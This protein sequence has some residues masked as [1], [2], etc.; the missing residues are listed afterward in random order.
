MTGPHV[1]L[2]I[3]ASPTSLAALS[4]AARLARHHHC[5]L[6]ALFVEDQDLLASAGHPFTREISALSGE[7]RPFD[8]EI[9]L[10]RLTQQRRQIEAV[11]TELNRDAPLRWH[12]EVVA[13][14][15]F[16]SIH[17]AAQAADWVV[18]GKA[19][20]SADHGAQLGSVARRLLETGGNRLLLWQSETGGNARPEPPHHPA[21]TR[22][23]RRALLPGG[24]PSPVAERLTPVVGLLATQ[25]AAE[26]VVQTAHA[27]AVATDRP[28]HLFLLSSVDPATLP[29]LVAW[30]QLGEP[31]LVLEIVESGTT[32]ADSPPDPSLFRTLQQSS[33][34]ALVVAD[35]AAEAL[36]LPLADLITAIHAPVIRVP[37]SGR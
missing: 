3:D 30:R 28:C 7:S 19:G 25:R 6:I 9:L 22:Q 12:F 37:L 20:W 29:S 26:T 17:A 15:V 13:G 21:R 33:V 16:E 5:E 14:P 8:R 2:L 32:E 10:T 1:L 4:S 18:M 31:P 23:P 34:S 36:G 27:L 24:R 35:D 11:L